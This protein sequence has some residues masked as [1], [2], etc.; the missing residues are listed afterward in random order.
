MAGKFRFA[1]RQSPA[2]KWFA[3]T[4]GEGWGVIEVDAVEVETGE[5]RALGQSFDEVTGRVSRE[6]LFT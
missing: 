1:D 6:R 3:L 2:R 4:G 5:F